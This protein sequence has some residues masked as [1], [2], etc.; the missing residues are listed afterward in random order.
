VNISNETLHQPIPST[1]ADVSPFESSAEPEVVYLAKLLASRTQ[2]R[3]LAVQ[4]EMQARKAFDSERQEL[5][6]ELTD[7]RRQI[8]E[9]QGYRRECAELK[10]ALNQAQAESERMLTEVRQEREQAVGSLE[11]KLAAVEKGFQ[12]W[13]QQLEAQRADEVRLLAGHRTEHQL[14]LA[15]RE[16]HFALRQRLGIDVEAYVAEMNRLRAELDDKYSQTERSQAELAHER[17]RIVE[18]QGENSSLAASIEELKHRPVPGTMS[19]FVLPPLPSDLA[20]TNPAAGKAPGEPHGPPLPGKHHPDLSAAAASSDGEVVGLANLLAVRIHERDLAVHKEIQAKKSF[21]D[22]RQ[23]LRRE[24]TDL[25]RQC[26]EQPGLRRECNQLKQQ[27][28]TLDQRLAEAVQALAEKTVASDAKQRELQSEVES[29]RGENQRLLA[30]LERKLAQTRGSHQGTMARPSL[31][32]H[33]DPELARII[34]A[35]GN[36]PDPIRRAMRT[37]TDVAD[38]QKNPG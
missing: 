26:E 6:R 23:D 22:E 12:E 37:L 29:R 28:A 13:H 30:E 34:S 10:A 3:D 25:R 20:L 19:D 1:Q 18:L 4:K 17:S 32:R 15:E 7:L 33:D 24:I 27:L 36:L 14:L 9:Q 21:D 5:R 16:A 2:E 8:E 31:P 38:P 11:E 35:W